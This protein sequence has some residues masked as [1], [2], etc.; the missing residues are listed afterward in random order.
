MKRSMSDLICN[1][2]DSNKV[3]ADT[4]RDHETI[5]GLKVKKVGRR[6]SIKGSVEGPIYLS[7]LTDDSFFR[8]MSNVL[9]LFHLQ[10]I[11]EGFLIEVHYQVFDSSFQSSQFYST[12]SYKCLH[13]Q[14]RL[15]IISHTHEDF[16][17]LRHIQCNACKS[18][19]RRKIDQYV[20]LTKVES[21]KVNVI[22]DENQ[23]GFSVG[24]NENVLINQVKVSTILQSLE[25]FA[26]SLFKEGSFDKA[27]EV[28]EH[29]IK[30]RKEIG[31]N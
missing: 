14:N 10:E 15:V 19:H 27:R 25:V 17:S 23:K 20:T 26:M 29:V 6:V 5:K 12:E 18:V 4:F 7:G 11:K 3:P 2:S 9:E 30:R 21:S 8:I 16:Y 22:S 13:C 1:N 24:N 28:Q 31:V